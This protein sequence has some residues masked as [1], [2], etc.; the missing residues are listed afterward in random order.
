MKIGLTGGIGAGK[1]QVLDFLKNAGVP[2]LQTD[3]LG[4][5]ILRSAPVLKKIRKYFGPSLLGPDGMVDR[6]RLAAEIFGNSEKQ[7]FLNRLLHPLIRRGT[8]QWAARLSKKKSSAS[9]LVVEVPLLFEKGFNRWFDQTLSVS[10]PRKIRHGRL[11]K[12]GWTMD[13][14]RRRENSQWSQKRKNQK[15]DWV[16]FNSGTKKELRYTV[17]RWL[18][19]IQKAANGALVP[20]RGSRP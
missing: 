9:F 10:A 1:S 20:K 16:L 5:E 8:A 2:V 4:H 3:F 19:R 13:E 14:I 17:H 15:A 7:K 18:G 12:R 11:L 6:K